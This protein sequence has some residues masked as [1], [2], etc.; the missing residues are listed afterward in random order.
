M[1]YHTC[2]TKVKRTRH[3][4]APRKSIQ[5]AIRNSHKLTFMAVSNCGGDKG[6]RTAD[7]LTA[8]QTLSRS[9]GYAPPKPMALESTTGQSIVAKFS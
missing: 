1:I 7:R 5:N 4:Y 3:S 8:S 6:D 2:L 9:I